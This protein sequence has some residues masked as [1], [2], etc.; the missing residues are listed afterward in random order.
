MEINEANL[1]EYSYV[2]EGTVFKYKD[3]YYIKTNYSNKI[4]DLKTGRLFDL[5]AN[6]KVQVFS[7]VQ[8]NCF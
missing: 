3:H 1:T 2:R 4:L 5:G 6:E 7:K 8:L